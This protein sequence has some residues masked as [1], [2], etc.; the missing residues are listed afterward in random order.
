MKAVIIALLSVLISR[1]VGVAADRSMTRAK[2]GSVVGDGNLNCIGK[3]I[4]SSIVD[5]CLGGWLE[6][7]HKVHDPVECTH[8][9][10]LSY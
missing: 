3:D 7:V 8:A 10:D 1:L 2:S 9:F 6:S 4:R 5:L